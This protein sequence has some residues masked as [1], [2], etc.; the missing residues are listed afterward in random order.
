VKC[1]HVRCTGPELVAVGR[2]S[3]RALVSLRGVHRLDVSGLG[4]ER[5]MFAGV[6]ALLLCG[7]MDK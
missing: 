2:S 3:F 6:S 5:H 1:I 4:L 7:W